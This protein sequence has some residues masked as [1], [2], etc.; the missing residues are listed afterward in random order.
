MMLHP[1]Q[2]VEPPANPGRFTHPDCRWP[3]R[4]RRTCSASSNKPPADSPLPRAGALSFLQPA[5]VR[6]QKNTGK[7]THHAMHHHEWD[8]VGS[9]DT[10]RLRR[11]ARGAEVTAHFRADATPKHILISVC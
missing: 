11:G 2:E 3:R 6:Y 1:P 10:R 8:P 5:S 9:P 7:E 4:V